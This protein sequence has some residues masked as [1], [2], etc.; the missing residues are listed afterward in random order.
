[1]P[2]MSCHQC[3]HHF[4]VDSRLKIFEF[5]Q[6]EGPQSVSTI[7]AHLALR[8]PTV[9]YHLQKMNQSGLLQAQKVGKKTL[10]NIN[11]NCPRR[12]QPCALS[13]LEL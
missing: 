6:K 10:Y 9:S 1:M 4:G 8:Q 2:E 7:V 3:I 5:L 12:H 13:R 11:Q